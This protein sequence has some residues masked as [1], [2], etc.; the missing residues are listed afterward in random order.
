LDNITLWHER[1]ISHSS[2]ERVILPDSTIALDYLIH[3]MIFII[4]NLH[5]YPE[6]M[7]DNINRTGGLFYSQ[8]LLLKLVE[9]G[10]SREEAYKVVQDLAMRVWN[11]EGTLPELCRKDKTISA[12]LNTKELDDIFDLRSYLKNICHVFKKVGLVS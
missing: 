5:V 7:M 12:K 2:A 4:A 10:L 6:T 3:R 8:S 11:R 9:K 1:D